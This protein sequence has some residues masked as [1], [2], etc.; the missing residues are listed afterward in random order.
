MT[1]PADINVGQTTFP[2]AAFVEKATLE[3]YC[4]QTGE[5]IT[6]PYNA[7]MPVSLKVLEHEIFT[8]APIKN[9]APGFSFAPLGLI[10]MYN[11]GGAIVDLKYEVKD[12]AKLSELDIEYGGEGSGLR[13]II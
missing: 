3:R 7:A 4:H 12:G 1:V 10:N 11:S 8:I 9:L 2:A 13:E 5:L 6:L